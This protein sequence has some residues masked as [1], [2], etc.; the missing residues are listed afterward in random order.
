MFKAKLF[1]AVLFICFQY[2]LQYSDELDNHYEISCA[3]VGSVPCTSGGCFQQS[4]FCDG[5]VNCEDGTDEQFC[6]THKA[7]PLICN[8][9][10][11]F[12]CANGL[13]CIPNFWI[14]NNRTDCDDGSDE[15]N[16]TD[17]LPI[18]KN[19][20]CKGF[21]CDHDKCISDLWVCDGIYDCKDKSDEF[22]QDL[23]RS[24]KSAHMGLVDTF[25]YKVP[26]SGVEHA[27]KCLDWRYCVTASRM[28]DGILDCR[29]ES[30]EGNFCYRWNTM[31]DH[32]KCYGNN[33]KCVPDREGPI[34]VCDPDTDIS[35]YN[36]ETHKCEDVNECIKDIP[37]CS[38][39]CTNLPR[40]FRCECEPGY[41]MDHLRYL[42]F[43][44]APEGMLFFSTPNDI[45][46][47]TIMTKKMVTVASGIKKAH[48]VTFDGTNVYW[49]ET[50][51]GHQAIFKARLDNIKDTKQ[52][53][54]GLGLEEPD[55]IA[56]DYLGDNIYFS[57]SERGTISACKFDGSSC[58]TIKAKTN[59]P[60]YVTLDVKNGLMYWADYMG[61]G[62]ILTAR[63][64][65]SHTEVLVDKLES[66]A[67]GL[68]LDVPNDRLYYVD[69]TIRVVILSLRRGYTLL[70]EPYHHPYSIS[71]FENTIYWND[72]TTNTIQMTD[73]VHGTAEMRHH[74]LKLNTSITGM[75]MYHPILMNATINPCKDNICSH[76]CLVTSNTTHVCGCP[77]GMELRDN[78]CARIGDYRAKYL[79]VAE[80]RL[81]TR[82][83]YDELGN[84]E[85][86]ATS[87][88]IGRVQAMTHDRVRD[89]LYIYD[90]KFRSI[91]YISMND[92]LSG[93]TKPLVQEGLVNVVD[94]DFD[95]ATDNLYILDAGRRVVEVYSSKSRKRAEVYKFGNEETPISFCLM[96]DYGRMMVAVVETDQHNNIHIDSIGLDGH[97]RR[98]VISNNLKGPHIRLRY[99]QQMDNV[100]IADES[101][102][103][104][105]YIHPDGKGKENYRELAT[106]VY[107]L[108]ITENLVFW[109]D[110]RTP[111]LFWADIHDTTQKIR[112]MDLS[113]FPNNTQLLIEASLLP[114][115]DSDPLWNHPCISSTNC[116][117]ICV[118]VS[119]E[120]Q[121]SPLVPFK[122]RCLCA[123]G[124]ALQG[125]TCVK[126]VHCREDQVTC[127]RSNKCIPKEKICNGV[128][129]CP[130][131]E[132]EEGCTPVNVDDICTPD[133]Y[134]C[135][136]VCL[137][138]KRTSMCNGKPISKP[139]VKS[140]C[141]TSEYQCANSSI[142]ISRSQLCDKKT[143]CP[144]GD[145][146][147]FYKCDTLSC[148]DSEFMCASGSCI[149]KT[150]VCD[151]EEDCSDG[152]DESNCGNV[153]CGPGFFQ[154]RS[155]DCIESKRRCDGKQ[156]CLDFSDEGD[157]EDPIFVETTVSSFL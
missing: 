122:Y 147:L 4:Q 44:P 85:S 19:A 54:A 84:P 8:A 40:N 81:F 134:F 48:G 51:K 152:S 3:E 46:Y 156:D 14:C 25:C 36:Y 69:K 77:D 31:C 23:C 111:R 49:V 63:M 45:R 32:F 157:C 34:C 135:G 144:S 140:I 96:P 73:K 18:D 61:R 138:R 52:I 79:V 2:T 22:R 9:T 119:H 50:A 115:S 118:Q 108:A 88:N 99:V 67:T 150:F 29:D 148:Y 37:Q 104:I 143:D 142:C 53:L 41:T 112:R 149:S 5:F 89:V 27:Y 47:L 6:V 127:H 146:E 39:K 101:N 133:E 114:P 35:L 56:I 117:D 80:G 110:R 66:F 91:Q 153:K 58:T 71:V 154:C 126:V 1:I 82:I 93:I 145:D 83:Q 136:G 59:R 17:T 13:S 107:S 68:A 55:S 57:D 130:L 33:T 137:N 20:T 106:T 151:G 24:A 98:H 42:C 43:A 60:S 30:D 113:L 72:W 124:Y 90:V 102:G 129:D 100:F 10:H 87:F 116:I 123:P 132:D 38:H 103:V 86:H 12:L 7:D 76:F 95:F 141:S 21:L 74:L 92:F 97:E 62:V 78:S 131:G 155:R 16:C 64:D 65:G 70:D 125:G 26:I 28:C 15:A 94:L 128:N 120:D 75:H 11:Q 139:E 109:T 121:Y 105:D